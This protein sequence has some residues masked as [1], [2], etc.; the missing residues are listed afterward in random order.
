MLP[1]GDEN[2][3]RIRPIVN[4][5]III[6]CIIVYIWQTSGS[7]TFY[8][9]TVYT[10]GIIP[11]MD[12][13]GFRFYTLVTNMFLH[14]G[15]SHLMGNL[16]F[17]WI[18]GDNIEDCCGHLKYLG[19]YLASGIIAAMFWVLTEWGN[20][21][22]AIGAS[23]AISGVLGAYYILYPNVLVKTIVGFGLFF[24]VTRVRANI[25]IGLWFLYQL[26]LALVSGFSSIAYWAHIGG[27]IG[28]IVLAYL[29]KPGLRKSPPQEEYEYRYYDL[30]DWR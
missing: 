15:W 12:L 16:M 24:R 10:Y 29:L 20:I 28:G 9:Y 7:L 18:F 5:S 21:Y 27:F 2:P 17:L 1:I 30:D 3:T 6:I 22:P 11:N 19:F 25:M 13:F 8:E 14:T 4:W 26:L 23:G